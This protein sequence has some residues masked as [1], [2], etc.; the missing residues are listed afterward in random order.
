MSDQYLTTVTCNG[1]SDVYYVDAGIYGIEEYGAVYIV[2]A[3]RPAI[4]DTGIGR[5]TDRILD[6]L[7]T[8]GI[9]RADVAYILPTHVHLDHAGGTG[10]LAQACPNASV[11][12]HE[13]GVR[14][15]VDPERLVEGTNR[16]VGSA[17]WEY[18]GDP[19]PVPNDRVEGLSGGETLDLGD[20]TLDVHHA[21]GHAPHQVVFENPENDLV[22]T[23]DAA[24][25]WVPTP[26]PGFARALSPPPDFDLEQCL[27]DVEMLRQLGP[28]VLC[29]AHFGPAPTG[30]KLD[31]FE[32]VLVDWVEAIERKRRE[33]EDDNAVVDHFASRN[34]VTH[35]WH[36]TQ[37]YEGTAMNVRGVLHYLDRREED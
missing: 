12:V 17:Q 23:A 13:F 33:L 2:N 29:Y 37:A 6:A 16:A 14:H 28:D 36:E 20:H 8:L 34:G 30:D 25:N 15:I 4:V 27:A 1:C 26:E 31:L 7:E 35:R 24:G 22:F 9:S 11:L 32:D 5:N 10:Y 19:V 3:D 21:P 18:Y